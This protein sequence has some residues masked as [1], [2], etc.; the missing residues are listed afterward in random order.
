[1]RGTGP[2]QEGG[3]WVEGSDV[4]KRS[5]YWLQTDV[6]DGVLSAVLLRRGRG[7]EFCQ[8]LVG[9]RDF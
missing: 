7:G 3:S 4:L 6:D 9:A 8:H 2:K 5:C 1:M